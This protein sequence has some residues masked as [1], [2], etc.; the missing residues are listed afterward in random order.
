M[1]PLKEYK[2]A[3]EKEIDEYMTRDAQARRGINQTEDNQ[4]D[5][6]LKQEPIDSQTE[7][8]LKDKEVSTAPLYPSNGRLTGQVEISHE[9]P[10]VNIKPYTTQPVRTSNP[11]TGREMNMKNVELPEW[12]PIK[13]IIPPIREIEESK[14]MQEQTTGERIG[15]G[16][17]QLKDKALEYAKKELNK[18]LY[19]MITS[20]PV[21]NVQKMANKHSIIKNVGYLGLPDAVDTYIG[22]L[23]QG[24]NYE[25]ENDRHPQKLSKI[26]QVTKVSKLKNKE[27]KDFIYN[28]YKRIKPDDP[29][30]VLD[31][32]SDASKRL[33]KSHG[34]AVLINKN[35]K[36][37]Y[38]NECRNKF[39]GVN[40]YS[41]SRLSSAYGLLTVFNPHID[42][43][44]NM[45]M[46][47][48][49]YDD[50][51][52]SGKKS[53]ILEAINDNAYKLQESGIV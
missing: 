20:N 2:T 38:N 44:N 4:A 52:A 23:T 46:Y 40:F 7:R 39:F 45:V 30:V 27:I 19:R 31:S 21:Y 1:K 50:Y 29:L 24:K 9:I 34:I 13:N 22:N 51:E 11:Y 43:N 10:A 37:I 25:E 5:T 47:A 33:K 32:N 26:A 36:Q 48:I 3:L 6:E 8:E 16:V 18:S 12:E 15:Q 49:D 17:E 35:L 41:D 28:T 53:G 42:T 14:R